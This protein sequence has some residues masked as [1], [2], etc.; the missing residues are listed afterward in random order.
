MSELA[1]EAIMSVSFEPNFW[2]L[3]IF[4]PPAPPVQVALFSL[5]LSFLIFKMRF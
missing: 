4:L 5:R 2:N 1:R 3:L